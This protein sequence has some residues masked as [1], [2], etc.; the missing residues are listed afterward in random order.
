MVACFALFA[1]KVQGDIPSLS[2]KYKLLYQIGMTERAITKAIAREYGLMLA[3]PLTLSALLSGFY[4]FAEMTGSGGD[5]RDYV[6]MYIPFQLVFLALS[7]VLVGGYMKKFCGR[8]VKM[9]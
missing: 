1:L 3:I 5:I 7:S 9:P 6:S 2:Y 8:A 4:M